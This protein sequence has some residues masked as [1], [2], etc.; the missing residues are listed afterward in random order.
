LRICSTTKV[1]IPIALAGLDLGEL[2]DEPPTADIEALLDGSP[3]R[4]QPKPAPPLHNS[5]SYHGR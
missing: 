3:L 4:R 5:E 2:G 1:W